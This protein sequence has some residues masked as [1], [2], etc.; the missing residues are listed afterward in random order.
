[1]KI[2]NFSN[3]CRI[4]N[5][6]ET[7]ITYSLELVDLASVLCRGGLVEYCIINF[8]NL[9]FHPLDEIFLL[10]D[11]LLCLAELSVECPLVN[12]VPQTEICGR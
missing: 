7:L 5:I 9:R 8:A 6:P 10:P 2:L 3:F 11:F 12:M 1:M 4:S